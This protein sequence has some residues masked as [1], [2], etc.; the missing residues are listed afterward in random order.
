MEQPWGLVEGSKVGSVKELEKPSA[1]FC[2][3]LASGNMCVAG[4]GGH[5]GVTY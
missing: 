2:R 1:D 5:H 3:S 4:L